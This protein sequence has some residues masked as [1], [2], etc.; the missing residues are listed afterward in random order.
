MSDGTRPYSEVVE[1]NPILAR[2]VPEAFWDHIGWARKNTAGA[3]SAMWQANLKKN[4]KL[5]KKHGAIAHDCGGLGIDKAVIGVGAGPSFNLNVDV[6]KQITQSSAVLSIKD[7]PF[8]TIVSNHQMKPCL[9][10]GIFPHFVALIDGSDVVFDQLCKDIPDGPKPI[11]LTALHTSHKVLKEWD[12]QGG[13]IRF[14]LSEDDEQ[15]EIFEKEAKEDP[16][17]IV[18]RE[19]ANVLNQMWIIAGR[20]LGSKVFMAVGNDLGYPPADSLEQRRAQFYADGDYT[21]NL[22]NRR[23]EANKKLDWMGFR[24]AKSMIT[25]DWGVDLVPFST[26]Q[27]LMTYK[28]W[29]EAQITANAEKSFHYYNC[30]EQGILGMCAKSVEK[31]AL[32][33]RNNWFLL[34]EVIP[35]NWHTRRLQDAARQFVEARECL[36]AIRTN[37][38]GAVGLASRAAGSATGASGK[39]ILTP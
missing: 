11:L 23:D 36:K 17:K 1:E 4:L 8:M 3:L 32:A 9:R 13:N 7:Q 12:R 21:A 33:D 30:S 20:L 34:D 35:K 16:E 39:L 25:N 18:S 26:S 29:I 38:L 19:G 37:A 15:K 10:A 5:Y 2:V 31:E 28:I 27:L 22:A 6:L 14:F 24:F